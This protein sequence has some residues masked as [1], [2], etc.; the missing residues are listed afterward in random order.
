MSKLR[1]EAVQSVS[2]VAAVAAAQMAS[3]A[4]SGAPMRIDQLRS[5]QAEL[6]SI[7][8]K[9]GESAL[10][11]PLALALALARALDPNPNLNLGESVS[12]TAAELGLVQRRQLRRQR[13]GAADA[14]M[15]TRPIA[16]LTFHAKHAAALEAQPTPRAGGEAPIAAAKAASG[17]EAQAEAKVEP[18]PGPGSE[19]ARG[20]SLACCC[21]DDVLVE[22]R[23]GAQGAEEAEEAEAEAGEAEEEAEEAEE[24]EAERQGQPAS[25]WGDSWRPLWHG[26]GDGL[27]EA[28]LGGLQPQPLELQTLNGLELHPL[29]PLTEQLTEQLTELDGYSYSFSDGVESYSF[30]A[31]SPTTPCVAYP[32]PSGPHLHPN[33]IPNH[34]PNL[35]PD[36]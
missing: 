24:A 6:S 21:G 26:R 12:A 30:C 11:L 14:S 4:V 7:V 18:E 25:F 19:A 1:E 16:P 3:A 9:S 2:A 36:P 33:R 5:L 17:A 22:L 8:A 35:T 13:R 34:N 15:R 20:V 31:A 23:Q 28:A 10:T 32:L 29:S 27:A